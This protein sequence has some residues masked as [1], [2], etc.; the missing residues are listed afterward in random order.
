MSGLI[1][2]IIKVKIIVMLGSIFV[3]LDFVLGLG[4]LLLVISCLKKLIDFL[5]ICVKL[6]L[7]LK[8]IKW[9]L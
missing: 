4:N 6:G 3:F 9:S 7:F 5:G 1:N 8:W 2:L